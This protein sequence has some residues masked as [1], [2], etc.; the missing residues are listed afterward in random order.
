MKTRYLDSACGFSLWCK[1]KVIVKVLLN[2][3]KPHAEEIIVE[4]LACFKTGRTTVEDI[5]TMIIIDL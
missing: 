4:E 2:M 3:L 5:F 1:C